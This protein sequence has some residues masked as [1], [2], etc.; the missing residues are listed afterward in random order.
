MR[1]DDLN[2]LF[3][4]YL[5]SAL[6]AAGFVAVIV[7]TVLH[8]RYIKRENEKR[9]RQLLLGLAHDI[10]TPITVIRGYAEGLKDGVADTP[11][12]RE[13]YLD[14][15]IDRTKVMDGL[16][17]DL[18]LYARMTG[19][20]MSYDMKSISVSEALQDYVEAASTDLSVRGAEL[21]FT[22]ITDGTEIINAD[23]VYIRC[24]L[25]NLVENSVKYKSGDSCCINMELSRVPEGLQLVVSDDGK[26]IRESELPFIFDSMYRGSAA[27]GGISGTGVGL[28]LVRR[29]IEDHGGSVWAKSE[30]GRGTSIGIV[31]GNSN[32]QTQYKGQ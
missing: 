6:L 11:E 29:I 10:R 30:L 2:G 12:K 23:P 20:G 17:S 3:L 8:G 18:M 9:E 32:K 25:D 16:L 7:I 31:L 14:R 28:W 21:S 15:I 26:G 19:E 1:H 4:D 24:A 27:N 22:D 5:I 13:V